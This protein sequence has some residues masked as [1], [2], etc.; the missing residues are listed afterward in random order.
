MEGAH[1]RG[2]RL[3]DLGFFFFEGWGGVKRGEVNIPGWGWYPGGHYVEPV[4]KIS[5]EVMPDSNKAK[6]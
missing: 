4:N 2:G 6:N 1:K 3:T 5:K